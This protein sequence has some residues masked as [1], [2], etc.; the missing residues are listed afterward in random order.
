VGAGSWTNIRQVAYTYYDGSTDTHGNAGDLKL[1]VIEDGSGNAIDTKYYR[2]YTTESGGF[3][4]ALKFVFEPQ[5]YAR[6]V[7]ALGTNLANLTDT[8]VAPYADFKFQYDTSK[9]VSSETVEG[10]G[11]S[12]SGGGARH[13]QL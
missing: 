8:Q 1:A 12:T 11:S 4:H 10:A 9:R 13:L 5:S 3:T 7:A 2:Y 6:L